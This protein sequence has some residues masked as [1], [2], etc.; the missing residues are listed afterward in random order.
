MVICIM[1]LDK[2]LMSK[3][4]GKARKSHNPE[5]Q[6]LVKDIMGHG[7]RL[8][9][10][11]PGNCKDRPNML[12]C[13][14]TGQIALHLLDYRKCTSRL[15]ICAF[16]LSFI[17]PFTHFP[18]DAKCLAQP[19]GTSNSTFPFSHSRR[20]LTGP[21]HRLHGNKNEPLH[22]PDTYLLQCRSVA[23][24]CLGSCCFRLAKHMLKLKLLEHPSTPC[25]A[26]VSTLYP[27]N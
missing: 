22:Q 17:S 7:Q 12:H 1:A 15:T 19:E 16:F 8:I 3:S 21:L 6:I 23:R 2:Y 18:S 25:P 9:Y 13:V 4:P 24:C 27:A 11:A 5:K 20:V 10:L 14:L 26:P